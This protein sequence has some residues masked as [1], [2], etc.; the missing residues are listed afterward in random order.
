[1]KHTIR[2][3]AVLTA[4]SILLVASAC[5]GNAPAGD[6]DVATITA[7]GSA[8]REV[9]P[10]EGEIYVTVLT[11]GETAEVQQLNATRTEDVIAALLD[12]GVLEENIETAS[13]DFHPTYRY[14]EMRG[15]NEVTGYEARHYLSVTL[16]DLDRAGEAIDAAVSAGAQQ[17]DGVH[18]KLSEQTREGYKAELIAE[19]VQLAKAKADAAARASEEEIDGVQNLFVNDYNDRPVYYAE[20][21]KGMGEAPASTEVMP[22]DVRIEVSVNVSYRLK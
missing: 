14:D 7:E 19:A 9:M 6:S 3:L 12:A 20:A 13:I 10:D 16:Q 18:F 1:M 2:I 4:A 22:G 8:F 11:R 17:V 15:E 5:T 21:I